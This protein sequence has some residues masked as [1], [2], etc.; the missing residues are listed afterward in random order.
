[1]DIGFICTIAYIIIG[2]ILAYKWFNDEFKE[3]YDE[4]SK[5][6]EI[7]P[8]MAS[9]LLLFMAIFWPLKATYNLITYGEL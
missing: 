9:I 7:Q 3:E 4:L 6:G 1:M 2:I 5:S 8:A